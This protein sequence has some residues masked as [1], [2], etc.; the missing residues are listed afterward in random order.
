MLTPDELD[1]LGLCPETRFARKPSAVSQALRAITNEVESGTAAW[2]F[3]NENGRKYRICVASDRDARERAYRLAYRVYRDSGYAPQNSDMIVSKYDSDPQTFTLLAEDSNGCE[4]GTITLIFDSGKGLPCDEIF[5]PEL[6]NLRKKGRR[7]VEVTRLAID[8]DHAG[9]RSLLI[10]LFNFQ[11]VFARQVK[12]YTDQ[13]IEVNPRHV[14]YYRRLLAFELAGP[15]RPCPRV[16]GAPAVLLRLE[17]VV[18]QQEIARASGTQRS[19]PR[20]LYAHFCSLA[21]EEPIAEFLARQH[22]PMSIDEAEYFGLS[23]PDTAQTPGPEL[24]VR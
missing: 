3:E 7:L 10:H 4:A 16:N 22:R 18:Q 9:S 2:R 17:H 12:R 19:S 21:Q 8:K 24:L 15:E 20:S 6:D 5:Q 1:T 13:M 14:N 23:T 11:S